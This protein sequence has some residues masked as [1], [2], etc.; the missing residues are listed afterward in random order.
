MKDQHIHLDYEHMTG[1][2]IIDA[3]KD[4]GVSYQDVEMILVGNHAPFT[5]GKDVQKAVYNSAVCEA[6]A[7][8]AYISLQID[9]DVKPM[10]ESLIKKHYDRKHGGGSYYGQ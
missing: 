1:H 6:I 4:R 3:L 2:Q 8:M 5:W 10:K 7:H 9:R